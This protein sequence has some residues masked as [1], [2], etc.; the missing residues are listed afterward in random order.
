MTDRTPTNKLSFQIEPD[1]QGGQ[2]TTVSINRHNI[3]PAPEKGKGRGTRTPPTAHILIGFDTEYQTNEEN[4]TRDTVEEGSRNELLSYQFCVRL[5]HD[6]A[7]LPE[8]A[9]TVGIIIP[10][11]GPGGRLSMEE[12]V[13]I[14]IGSFIEKHP[15]VQ[16]PQNVY[17]IGHFTRADLP[18]F[19]DFRNQARELM[20]N[21]RSTFITLESYIPVP[22]SD[23]QGEFGTF[24]VT[25]RDTIAL[26]PANAKSL[27]EVGKIVGLEKIVLDPDPAKEIEIKSHMADFR[28]RDWP[29]F[30]EYAIR[31]AEVCVRY[32][33]RII[34][35][36]Q[37]L[38]RKFQMPATLTGFGTKLV[39]ADWNRKGLSQYEMLGREQVKDAAFNRRRGHYVTKLVTPFIEEIYH[40]LL[41]ATE[42]Y[43]GGRNEQ[44]IF[45][46]ADEGEWRD[47]DL[48]S[49]YPTAMTLIGIPDWKGCRHID[50]F[51]GIDAL[52]LAYFSVDFEF[53]ETV[54][55]PVLPVRTANGIIFPRKGNSKCSSPELDLAI[56]L[57]ATIRIKRAVL[58]PSDRS[59]SVFRG[60]IQ[61]TIRNRNEHAKGTFDNL[62]WKEVGNS[63]YG[64]T[65][66]GLKQKRVYDLRDDDMVKLPE[67]EI[68]QPYFAAFITSYTRAVLGEILNGFS[69]QV[70]VFS[71][72]TDGFLSNASDQEIENATSGPVFKTFIDGRRQ[73]GASD[74]PLEV[75]HRV[76]QPIGWRTR[77]SATL[78]AGDGKDGIVLQKGGLKT[79]AEF[80]IE[81]ENLYTIR[82]FLDRKPDSMVRYKSGVGLKDMIRL[83][84]DFV[85]RSVS[86]YL[87]MEFDW[88]RAPVNARE[89]SFEFEGRSH[90]HL[91]F[92][93][94]PLANVAEFNKVREAWENYSKKPRKNLKS[95]SD[96]DKFQLY[97]ETNIDQERDMVKYMR[98]T[99]GDLH[100]VRRDLCI[101]FKKLQAG[102]DLVTRNRRITHIEFSEALVACGIPCKTTD[103]ENGKKSEFKPHQT[104]RTERVVEALDALKV[105]YFPELEIDLILT[106]KPEENSHQSD[107]S[108][109][110]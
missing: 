71:V 18:A 34:R 70:Q 84:T 3:L 13:R 15:D 55:F 99:D 22:V 75:K 45:G 86:K 73:L 105:E 42:A 54:R 109:A 28:S 49:A 51:D 88:K 7:E 36:Y 33:E 16:L 60:F 78:K 102:F 68:T 90:S 98:K 4:E 10:Q 101:A 11:N 21:V 103:V 65:A 59:D 20:A 110:A 38:F 27:A 79:N 30:C 62:F 80:T 61:T 23:E 1:D 91:T 63:T 24:K 26:A 57:G 66:Q 82:Q 31:D 58:V 50:S 95:F 53:P 72:T 14:A 2:T 35:Q 25:L 87:S 41:I 106:E 47:H 32:A 46:V 39:I 5:I 9:E 83:D 67:S 77:G 12:F 93:T 6:D 92:E 104:F 43:H 56:R 29:F 100:R 94:K 40:D 108:R 17:L 64:K 48:S 69:N 96:F 107:L 85:F 19:Q 37:K 74:S 81:Q 89:V 97:V 76:R 52:D 44:Y 8:L